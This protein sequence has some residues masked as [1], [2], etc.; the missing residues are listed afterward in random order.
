MARQSDT[1]HRQ[2]DTL[3][4]NFVYK[5][6]RDWQATMGIDNVRKEAVQRIVVIIELAVE[7]LFLKKKL[8]KMSEQR[9]RLRAANA[10]ADGVGIALQRRV[11]TDN[12]CHVRTMARNSDRTVE[13]GIRGVQGVK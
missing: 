3:C 6:Q 4:D 8:V 1:P 5:T 10:R 12:V 13:E 11:D 7:P 9:L 2:S